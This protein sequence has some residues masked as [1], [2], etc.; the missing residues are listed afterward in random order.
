M[1]EPAI[2]AETVKPESDERYSFVVFLVH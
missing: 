2:I 1:M